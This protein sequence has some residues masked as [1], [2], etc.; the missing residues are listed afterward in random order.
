MLVT[1]LKQQMAEALERKAS[2]IQQNL[3]SAE[4]SA[5]DISRDKRRALINMRKLKRRLEKEKRFG[6]KKTP[7]VIRELVIP[8]TGLTVKEVSSR[9]SLKIPFVIEKLEG[10]GEV[11][12]GM[13]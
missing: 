10:M 7:T 5:R 13:C 6:K 1:S 12:E 9:L 2:S 8:H 11:L 4:R 3:T